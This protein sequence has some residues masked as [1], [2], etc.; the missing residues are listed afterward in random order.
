MMS[1]Y[2][3]VLTGRETSPLW[4]LVNLSKS[5]DLLGWHRPPEMSSKRPTLSPVDLVIGERRLVQS[6]H[7]ILNNLRK[8]VLIQDCCWRSHRQEYNGNINESFYTDNQCDT[9]NIIN[10]SQFCKF[11]DAF[12]QSVRVVQTSLIFLIH[13]PVAAF[14]NS[15]NQSAVEDDLVHFATAALA[16]GQYKHWL[17]IKKIIIYIF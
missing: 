8:W 9:L 15:T 10:T 17:Y 11:S 3:S 6:S 16:G 12:S 14:L 1:W 5:S 13:L 2:G 7:A 4:H